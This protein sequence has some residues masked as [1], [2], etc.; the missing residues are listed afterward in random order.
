MG[1]YTENSPSGEIDPISILDQE[2][3]N[4]EQNEQCGLLRIKT[5]N[6][7]MEEAASMPVPRQLFGVFIHENELVIFFADTGAGKT[8]L[9]LQVAEA[10]AN[11]ISTLK[12]PNDSGP[13][14]VLFL[15]CELSAKQQQKRYSDNFKDTAVFSDY[16][17]RAEL[18]F[19]DPNDYSEEGIIQSIELA[20]SQNNFEVIIVDN[21]TYLSRDAE[22]SKEA[23]P[24]MK[25]LK[26]LKERTNVTIVLLAHTPK[27][28]LY[29]EISVNDLAGSKALSNFA[30]SI[31]CMGRSNIDTP[32]RYLKQIKARNSDLVYHRDNVLSIQLTQLRPNFLGFEFLGFGYEKEHLKDKGSSLEDLAPEIGE[33]S[34]K[35]FSQRD[36]ASQLGIAVSTVNKYVR[37]CST[38]TNSNDTPLERTPEQDTEIEELPF[39]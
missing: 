1:K 12:L 10:I 33:L 18:S 5:M 32:V 4:I 2:V 19:D 22:K 14:K 35:G 26:Q 25:Y 34:D 29:R 28:D 7:T 11:G 24:L 27:R 16:L 21:I 23:A 20:L 36:I 15:D 8:M 6:K 39:D 3:S 37:R 30:D 17:Y 9:I 38:R 13:K 31:F